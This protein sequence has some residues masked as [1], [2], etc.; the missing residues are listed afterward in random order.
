MS[1]FVQLF[2]QLGLPAIL[3]IDLF[4]K[5]YSQRRE[6]LLD[7]V[8]VGVILLF[9]FQ[10]ARWDWFSYYFR[11]LLLPVFGL[12]AYVAYRCIDRKKDEPVPEVNPVKEYINFGVKGFIILVAVVFNLAMFRGSFSPPGAVELGYPLR[13]GIYY[14]GGGGANR[15]INA[16]NAFPPQDYAIDVVRLNA[17]G[18]RAMGINPEALTDYAIFG[19]RIHAPCSGQIIVAE[20]GHIDNMPPARDTTSLA[21]NHVV[22]ACKGVEVLMA[23]M[24]EGSVTVEAGE[25]VVEGFVL[26]EVGNSGHSSQPHLHMHAERGGEAGVIL[27]GEGVPMRFSRRFLVRNSLFSGRASTN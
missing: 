25:E 3:L 17:F 11:L 12:V 19:N 21:G 20:D 7:I 23:H 6:W 2:L 14:V 13:E 22:I 26:G 4:K 9:V 1:L 24:K 15:W 16:H 18:N 10:T 5:E 27:N 8:L